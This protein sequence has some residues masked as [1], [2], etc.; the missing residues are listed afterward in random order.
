MST[1]ARPQ[2]DYCTRLARFGFQ[3]KA[4]PQ[5]IPEDILKGRHDHRKPYSGDNGIQFELI[6]GATKP[7]E[8]I[9]WMTP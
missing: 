8:E 5:G 3:C 1:G 9:F 7:L 6:P 4:F 2:C